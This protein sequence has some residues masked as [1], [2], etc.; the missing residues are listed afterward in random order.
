VLLCRYSG[1]GRVPRSAHS[2]AL[3]AQHLLDTSKATDEFATKLNALPIFTGTFHCPDDNAAVVIAFFRYGA[4]ANADD[5][6]RSISG[7][8]NVKAKR[9]FGWKPRYASW[10]LGFARGLG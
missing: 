3:I 6:S 8:S 1:L 10:R 5:P 4:A 7:A 2:L 9:E